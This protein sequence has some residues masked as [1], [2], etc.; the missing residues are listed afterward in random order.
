M[1]LNTGRV[2]T[3]RKYTEL[4]I[5]DA[6]IRQVESLALAEGQPKIKHG[7]PTF[8]WTPDQPIIFDD[9]DEHDDEE[10]PDIDDFEHPQQH[11]DDHEIEIMDDHD[12]NDID[13]DGSHN[14]EDENNDIDEEE[15]D[16]NEETIAE[17]LLDVDDEQDDENDDIDDDDSVGIVLETI[18][19]EDDEEETDVAPDGDQRSARAHGHNLRGNRGRD[20]SHRLDH[21]M[22]EPASKKSYDKQYTPDMMHTFLQQSTE[23]K[24][25]GMQFLQQAVEKIDESPKDLHEYACHFMFTQMTADAGI[26]K[27]GQLAVEARG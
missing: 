11:D 13:D 17:E 8:G 9:Y 7:C 15:Q 21:V 2:I 14:N 24:V 23:E 27:H 5:T 25:Y 12:N 4:P 22:D 18:T 19:D 26:K 10:D 20:Y 3:R 16:Q 6:V 1:N